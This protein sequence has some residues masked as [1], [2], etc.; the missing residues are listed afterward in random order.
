LYLKEET[1]ADLSKTY[2]P[3]DHEQALYHWWESQ[4]YF[5]PETMT[6]KGLVSQE[7]KRFCI[8]MPRP[9]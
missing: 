4:G 9:T 3:K 7:G 6:A 1:M 5:K 8:T 2:N